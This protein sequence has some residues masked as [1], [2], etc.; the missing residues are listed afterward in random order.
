MSILLDEALA[1]NIN[2][3]LNVKFNSFL[4][5]LKDIAPVQEVIVVHNSTAEVRLK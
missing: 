5:G 1:L 3:N 2:T 4:V